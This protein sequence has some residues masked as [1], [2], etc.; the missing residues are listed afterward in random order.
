MIHIARS[1]LTWMI[2]VATVSGSGAIL[3]A[4]LRHARAAG[5]VAGY[6]DAARVR[7]GRHLWAVPAGPDTRRAAR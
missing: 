2:L 4:G 7:P 3:A 5:Y 6:C 1:P